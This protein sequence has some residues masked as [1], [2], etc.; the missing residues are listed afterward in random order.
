MGLGGNRN[1]RQSVPSDWLVDER[2]IRRN[3]SARL[4]EPSNS[5]DKQTISKG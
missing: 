3:V 2:I 4:N 1:L 5:D